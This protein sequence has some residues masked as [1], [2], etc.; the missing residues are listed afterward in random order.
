MAIALVFRQEL[1]D[2]REHH[3]ARRDA[4][5]LAQVRAALR[6]HRRLPQEALT[7]RKRA[8]E[9]VVQIVPVREHHDRGVLHLRRE[10]HTACVER[11]RETLPRPLRVPH[12]ANAMIT[13]RTTRLA[14]FKPTIALAET[15]LLQRCTQRLLQRDVHR[16]EMMIPRHFLG[17]LATP[18]ILKDDEVPNQI[19]EPA[20]LEDTLNRHLQLGNTGVR[21]FITRNRPPRLEPF[22]ACTQS[23][24]PA[25]DTIR[26]HERAVVHEQRRNLLLIRLQLLPRRPDRRILIRRILELNHRQRQPIHKDH[27]IRPPIVLILHHRKLIHRQPVIAL[28][29]LEVHHPDLRPR[30]GTVLPPILHRDT[31]NKHAMKDVIA[32]KKRRAGDEFEFA[33]RI[34]NSLRR[35]VGVQTHESRSEPPFKEDVVK[36]GVGAFGVGFS[37]RD[38]GAIDRAEIEAIEPVESS[39]FDDGF[40]EADHLDARPRRALSSGPRTKREIFATTSRRLGA[41]RRLLSRKAFHC[42]CF[43]T[44]PANSSVR[45]TGNSSGSVVL[46]RSKVAAIASPS[47]PGSIAPSRAS[48]YRS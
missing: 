16:M 5:L 15:A 6:L 36:I 32:S 7:A 47:K 4:Q 24:D 31:I 37:E 34:L 41:S 22:L 20:L 27:N 8:E 43:L 14:R 21:R 30:N 26:D 12:D 28:R 45:P 9:L 48:A 39:L 40:G 13:G 2:G 10:D 18:I 23:A 35:K 42:A 25:L 46:R 1:L 29:I 11:H 33:I 3:T 38:V 19:E 17:E 44:S